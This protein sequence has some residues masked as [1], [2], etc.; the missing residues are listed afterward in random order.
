[1][2]NSAFILRNTLIPIAHKPV[3]VELDLGTA[4]TEVSLNISGIGYLINNYDIGDGQITLKFICKDSSIFTMSQT[5]LKHFNAIA[6]EFRDIKVTNIV[7]TGKTIK[8]IV[9]QHIPIGG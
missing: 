8:F 2:P 1:M 4:R 9:L 7:Q 6:F 5:D 3:W